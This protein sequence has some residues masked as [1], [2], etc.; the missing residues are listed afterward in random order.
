[1][2]EL[3]LS[4]VTD[5][6]IRLLVY[7]PVS[8][9]TN[10]CSPRGLNDLFIE[11]RAF[12]RSYDLTPRPPLPFLSWQQLVSLSQSSW[13]QI[14]SP[15][16]GD[17]VDSGIGL[18]YRPLVRQPYFRVDYSSSEGLRIWLLCVAGRAYWQERGEGMGVEPNYTTARNPGPLLIVQYSVAAPVYLW[19][20]SGKKFTDRGS[21]VPKQE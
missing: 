14:L 13:G 21:R 15:W 20:G 1:M 6:W 3:T 7:T 18:S 16:L 11:G 9:H 2:S 8:R 19:T 4:P 12:L 5:L 10:G 17:I